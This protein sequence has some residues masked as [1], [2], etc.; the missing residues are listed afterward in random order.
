MPAK[1][2]LLGQVFGTLTAVEELTGKMRRKT[3]KNENLN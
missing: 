2:D 3:G 1:I